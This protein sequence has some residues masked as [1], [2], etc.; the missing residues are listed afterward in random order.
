VAVTDQY[1][2]WTG[3]NRIRE[4]TRPGG[5]AAQKPIMAYYQLVSSHT[6]YDSIPP[7]IEDW[8]ELGNGDIYNQRAAEIRYFDRNRLNAGRQPPSRLAEPA[9][10][11]TALCPATPTA[12]SQ[13]ERQ[14]TSTW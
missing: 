8:D 10:S 2:I 4:L 11:P 12:C 9:R 14:N 3:H 6:P 7:V 5:E 13:P 1:A